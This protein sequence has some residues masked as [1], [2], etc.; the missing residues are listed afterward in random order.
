MSKMKLYADAEKLFLYE[1]MSPDDIAEHLQISRRTV[2]YWKKK[3]DWDKK[4]AEK[5]KNKET[6]SKDLF[7]FI[8]KLM[9]KITTDL[10]NKVSVNQALFYSLNNLLKCMPDLQKYETE[11]KNFKEPKDDIFSEEFIKEIRREFLNW[12][13]EK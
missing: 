13:P 10:E 6:M 7:E 1:R 4:L 12:E 5:L 2:Y 9:K 11:V 3:F 8:R